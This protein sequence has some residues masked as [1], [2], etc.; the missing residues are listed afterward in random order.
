L[1]VAAAKQSAAAFVKAESQKPHD[2]QEIRWSKPTILE[3]NI[4]F[5]GSF[6]P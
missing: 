6:H 5:A 2:S 4:H 3:M 1:E